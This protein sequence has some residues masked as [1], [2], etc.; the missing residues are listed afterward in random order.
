MKR[1]LFV[2]DEPRAL[3]GLRRMLYPFRNDWEMV[4]VSSGREALQQLEASEF[5]VL[6]TDIRMP[7]M[8]GIELLAEV[9]NRHPGVV[10]MVLSGTAD[11]DMTLRSVTLAHQYLMKPCDAKTV[12]AK[13]EHALNFHPTLENPALM[14]VISRLHSLPSIPAVYMKLMEALQSP[15]VSIAEVGQIISQDLGMTA[16]VLQLVNSAFFGISRH[17][18]TPAEAAVYLGIDTVKALALNVA[19]FSKFNS[20]ASPFFSIDRLQEH[21]S[22]VGLLAR[23]I[24]KSLGQ[25]KAAIEDALVAGMLHDIGKLVLACNYPEQYQEVQLLARE[26]SIPVWE[27]ERAIFGT[28]HGEVGAYLLWLWG[29]P[30][31]ITEIVAR[32]HRVQVESTLTA[33]PLLAVQLADGLS[34]TGSDQHLD[35]QRLAALGLPDHLA[36]G[37]S[38]REEVTGGSKC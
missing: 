36:D 8:T 32:H 23:N 26:K 27:A 16:R 28:A 29:I 10:R 33:T 2:D 30:G 34:N 12:R 13:V 5:D 35:P 3:D 20:M 7:E 1:I 4:F 24:A 14:Q 6:M 11:Q 22:E 38:M 17:I 21:S 31:A 19:V 25:S 37:K 15:A 9:A 18:T